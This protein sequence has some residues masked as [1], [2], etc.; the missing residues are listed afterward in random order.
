MTIKLTTMTDKVTY[1]YGGHN[2]EVTPQEIAASLTDF[3]QAEELIE[4]ILKEMK[5]RGHDV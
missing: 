2:L 4:A 1:S 3:A 5:E